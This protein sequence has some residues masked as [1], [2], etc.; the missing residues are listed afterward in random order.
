MGGAGR[1]NRTAGIPHHG[2][3]G[4]PGW[5]G[6]YN[7]FSGAG[8]ASIYWSPKNGAHS[9]TG[10]VRA[11]WASLGWET[12]LGYPTTDTRI[13]LDSVGAY[14]HFSAGGGTSIYWSPKTGAHYV[15]GAIRAKWAELGWETG[16][17][18]IRP[19]MRRAPR[20]RWAGTTTS[21]DRTGRRSTGRRLARALRSRVSSGPSGHPSAGRRAGWLSDQRPVF[22]PDRSGI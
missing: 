17:W 18:A 19:R 7:H 13:S 2:P 6:R 14:N 3:E 11:K 8:G 4:H 15:L 16:P 1:G 21:P 10:A 9:V 12:G 5:G 22:D 20:I